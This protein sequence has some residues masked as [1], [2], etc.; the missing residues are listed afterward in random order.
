MNSRISLSPKKVSFKIL[1]DR[2]FYANDLDA[3]QLNLRH[4]KIVDSLFKGLYRKQILALLQKV[5]IFKNFPKLGVMFQDMSPLLADVRLRSL[6]FDL[7]SRRFEKD[8]IEFVVGVE[9]RGLALALGLAERL[10]AG[11]LP[12]RKQGKLPGQLNSKSYEKEYGVDAL[13]LS[14]DVALEGK[15]VLVVD[16]LIATG[17]SLMAAAH[18]VRKSGGV[19]VDATSVLEVKDLRARVNLGCSSFVLLGDRVLD[20]DK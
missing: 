6:L 8:R 5:R 7:W 2:V 3:S 12:I 20:L 14:L 10:N 16:D 15:R 18:L 11:Y 9:S 1:D 19:L 4:R 17:G 13:E